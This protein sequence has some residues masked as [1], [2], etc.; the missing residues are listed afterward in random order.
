MTRN[1]S[2]PPGVIIP[3]LGYADVRTAVTWLCRTFGFRERLRI[4]DHRAQLLL[5]GAALVVTSM[6]GTLDLPHPA[7]AIMV[8][9]A[10]VDG[11]YAHA[12]ECG[13]HVNGP[14]AD[15]PYGERQ[16]SVEDIGGHR[17]TFSQSI[18]DI[19]PSAWGGSGSISRKQD[20]R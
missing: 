10:D 19:A 1:R 13:A 12:L 4:G 2:M 7:H 16:Y 14:P 11:H 15:F 5:D 18:A 20:A 17:W 6:A 8:R 9:V 3:E